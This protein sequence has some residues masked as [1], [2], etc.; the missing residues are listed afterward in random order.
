MRRV[1][2]A[3]IAVKVPI[4]AGPGCDYETKMKC[5]KTLTLS[6]SRGLEV[7]VSACSG[8]EGRSG[9]GSIYAA[10]ICV[11]IGWPWVPKCCV[12]YWIIESIS[13]R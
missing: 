4:A 5:K 13:T 12:N 6:S 3:E 8:K 2:E 1:V 11:V 7:S 9:S 10:A